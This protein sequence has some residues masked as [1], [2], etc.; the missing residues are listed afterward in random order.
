MKITVSASTSVLQKLVVSVLFIL[1]FFLTACAGPKHMITMDMKPII[2]PKTEKAVL[3]IVRTTSF[4]GAVTIENYLDRHMIGQTKGK[5]YFITDVNP[6]QHYIMSH[7]ENWVV[8]RIT[9]EAG[10]IY[11]LDQG[12]YPGIWMARTGFSPMTAEEGMKQ[13]NE[14]GCDYRVLNAQDP[15]E[16]MSET[17]YDEA[18]SDFEKEV[19]EDPA[20]HK[21]TLEYRGYSSL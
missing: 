14:S 13:I 18:K 9:F 7:A 3:V 19:K 12:I 6:G 17:D 1:P 4:G 8:A 5:S 16:D 20:R 11:F 15:G 10:R 21:N 2:A